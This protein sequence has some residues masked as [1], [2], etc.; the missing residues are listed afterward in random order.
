MIKCYTEEEQIF[1][2]HEAIKEAKKALKNDEVPIGAVIVKDG[3]I[4]ARGYNKKEK[5]NDATCHAEIMAIKKASKVLNDW[6]L[7]ECDMFVTLE[8]C[9]MCSG[10][11]VSARINRVFYATKDNTTNLS[12]LDVLEHKF[13]NHKTI[14]IKST[15]ED[16]SKNIIR[17][18][19]ISKRK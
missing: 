9:V 14:A 3:K 2:M 19:F 17:Q 11:I 13:M 1:Y 10:A 5:N 16:E 15:C 6:R 7:S 12:G 8:P 4:I 18:F